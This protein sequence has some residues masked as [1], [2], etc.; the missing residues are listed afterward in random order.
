M[1]W[2]LR[3]ATAKDLPTLVRHR[4]AMW[5]EMGRVAP[6]EHDP[7]SQAYG[8]WFLARMRRGALTAFIAEE[9]GEV[10]AS[11]GVWIQEVQPRPGHPCTQWGY[12][13]SIYTEPF[14]RGRGLAKAIVQAC[15]DKAKEV[16]CTRATLHASDAGRPMYEAFGFERTD[17]MW[18]DLRP[19]EKRPKRR[20][21]PKREAA[22][23]DA[24][25]RGG[26]TGRPRPA[27]R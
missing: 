1:A 14:A 24:I 19:P 20:Q 11:G 15:I 9:G 26:A 16:G 18:L 12:I 3:K 10:L 25:V 27:R 6:G 5:V 8:K 4:D 21:A 2:T 22:A 17:E 23:G 13:L 7:T